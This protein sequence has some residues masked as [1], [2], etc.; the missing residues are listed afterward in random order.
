[1]TLMPLISL[2]SLSLVVTV[3][4]LSSAR[5]HAAGITHYRIVIVRPGDT[6]WSI[7]AARTG[8]NESIEE[9][10]DRIT[11]ANHLR[12]AEL[13]PGQHLRIPL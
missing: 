5:L 3:P 8:S 6:L 10:I 13:R 4:V 7:A 12:S 9:A 11:A 2:L 1:M